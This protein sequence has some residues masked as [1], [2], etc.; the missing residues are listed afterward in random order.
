MLASPSRLRVKRRAIPYP[1]GSSASFISGRISTSKPNVYRSIAF[2]NVFTC[3]S[4]GYCFA[5]CLLPV[6]KREYIW[7][8]GVRSRM[9]QR[10]KF[11]RFQFGIGSWGGRGGNKWMHRWWCFLWGRL[12]YQVVISISA[13]V[14]FFVSSHALRECMNAMFWLK[15][16]VI[17]LY[18][19]IG[20]GLSSKIGAKSKFFSMSLA[21][22]KPFFCIVVMA[23]HTLQPCD[24]NVNIK[25]P[26]LK[27]FLHLHH[28]LL[29]RASCQLTVSRDSAVFAGPNSWHSCL[30]GEGMYCAAKT[31]NAPSMFRLFDPYMIW[32]LKGPS[33]TFLSVVIEEQHEMTDDEKTKLERKKKKSMLQQD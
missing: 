6:K 1:M 17:Q 5:L 26:M 24:V 4:V 13:V 10:S 32:K 16:D 23:T 2:K 14:S 29:Q 20:K 25:R 3:V 7:T 28:W 18:V 15:H 19:S 27:Y 31:G 30:D 21:E 12:R 33:S 11:S 9:L 22:P 8:A